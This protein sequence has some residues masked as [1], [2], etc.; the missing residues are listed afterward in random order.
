MQTPRTA[1]EMHNRQ[2]LT[3]ELT[4][5]HPIFLFIFIVSTWRINLRHLQLDTN[6]SNGYTYQLT[7]VHILQDR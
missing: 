3:L 5:I 1:P 2:P 7:N 6:Q 4:P